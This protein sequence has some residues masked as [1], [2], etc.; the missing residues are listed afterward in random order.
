MRQH[1][2]IFAEQR[3]NTEVNKILKSIS[4]IIDSINTIRNK[5]SIAHPNEVLLDESE[6]ILAINCSRSL[7][8]YL[9]SKLNKQSI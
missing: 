8:H 2:P 6:A 1:H 3:D 7:L 4:T 5:S 9:D